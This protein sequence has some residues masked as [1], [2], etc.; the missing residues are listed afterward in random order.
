MKALYSVNTWIAF[1]IAEVYYHNTHY[2]WCAPFFNANGA[3]PP[4]SDPSR[5]YNIIAEDV[6]G[7]DKHSSKISQNR[8]G[9]IK[10]ADIKLQEGVINKEQHKEILEIA[11]NAEFLDFR[12]LVYVIPYS[13][14]KDVAKPASIKIKANYFSKEF[15]IETLKPEQFDILDL[16]KI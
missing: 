5:I 16:L 12:P 11:N 9:L 10:G 3:N 15:I 1:K 7:K 14:V 6:L 13:L 8:A 2:V 4:S